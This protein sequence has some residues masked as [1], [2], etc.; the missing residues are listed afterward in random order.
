MQIQP[1]LNDITDQLKEAQIKLGFGPSTVKL[2]Y[3]PASLAVLT[4]VTSADVPA[5]AT[6]LAA[7]PAF[8]ASPLGRLSFAPHD[9]RVEITI[10]QDGVRYVHEQVEASPFLQALIGLFAGHHHASMEDVAALFDQQNAP[11]VRRDMPTGGEFDCVLF[12]PDGLPDGYYYFFKEE[13]GH[14]SYHRFRPE[15]A[16][17]LLK[18]T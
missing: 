2:Y 12:F 7:E 16:A 18:N 8:T 5:M 14:L 3:N 11:Y 4:G 15:D 6:A 17:Q 13:M 9:D 1:L 10:P